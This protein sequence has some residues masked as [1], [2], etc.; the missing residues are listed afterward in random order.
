MINNTFGLDMARGQQ[1]LGATQLPVK[2]WDGDK[3]KM[4]CHFY[5]QR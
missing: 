1:Q 3:I 4:F 2:F 5:W